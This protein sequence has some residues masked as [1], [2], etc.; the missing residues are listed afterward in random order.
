[1]LVLNETVKFLPNLKVV[2][3]EMKVST[4]T[5][6]IK[7]T[8]FVFFYMRVKAKTDFYAANERERKER[9]R[10]CVDMSLC[11]RVCV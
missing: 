6:A 11:I 10:E 9:E 5:F 8:N 2:K 7:I 1:M 3:Y 4:C